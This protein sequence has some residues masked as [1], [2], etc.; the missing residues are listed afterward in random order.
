MLNIN[1]INEK[2][3]WKL[4]FLHYM[5]LKSEV[6]PIIVHLTRNL[7]FTDTESFEFKVIHRFIN[8]NDNLYK[9][10]IIDRPKC[11]YCTSVDTIEHHFYYCCISIEFWRKLSQVI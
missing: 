11:S 9:W 4:N 3:N 8:C 2:L 6:S 1:T 10:K 7:P 5:R